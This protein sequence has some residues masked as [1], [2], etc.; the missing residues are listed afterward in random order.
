M[1]IERVA[2]AY[3]TSRLTMPSGPRLATTR[4][5]SPATLERSTS[6]KAGGIALP[7]GIAIIT[8]VDTLPDG[9]P[10]VHVQR[11]G[12]GGAARWG[13]QGAEVATATGGQTD[14]GL[15]SDGAGGAVVVWIDARPSGPG[16]YAQRL[17]AAGT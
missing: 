13:A 8:V 16:L 7:G 3:T 15:V 2:G 4:A 6:P 11:V 10:R 5:P 17:D 9:T 1:S 14:P 12:P